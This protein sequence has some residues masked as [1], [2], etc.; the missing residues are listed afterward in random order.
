M[1]TSELIKILQ[2]RL[3]TYGDTEVVVSSAEDFD[4]GIHSD[5]E[6]ITPLEVFYDS[7][8]TQ[9][10][11]PRILNTLIIKSDEEE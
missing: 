10:D 11:S 8:G 9:I 6:I 3:D 7:N 1:K 5:I 4:L 2:A